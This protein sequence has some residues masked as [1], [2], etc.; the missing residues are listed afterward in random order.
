MKH[1]KLI[2]VFV[3]S[4][5]SGAVHASNG[6]FSMVFFLIIVMAIIIDKACNK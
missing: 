1:K 6:V 3:L 4:A 2:S 5:Q